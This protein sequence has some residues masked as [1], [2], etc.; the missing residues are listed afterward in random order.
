M[1]Q[2]CAES[3]P[4]S[5]GEDLAPGVAPPVRRDRGMSMSAEFSATRYWYRLVVRGECGP[6]VA[7]LFGDVAI[8]SGHGRTS[9]TFPVRD[10]SELYGM[11][12]RIQDLALHLISLTELGSAGTGPESGDELRRIHRPGRGP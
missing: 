8:E 6:L 12:D 5:E 2:A 3:A 9:I 1:Y 11:L 7:G 4:V 10:D